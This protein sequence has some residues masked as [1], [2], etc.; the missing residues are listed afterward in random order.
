MWELLDEYKASNSANSQ[1]SDY[2][3][4]CINDRD[5]VEPPNFLVVKGYVQFRVLKWSAGNDDG[6]YCHDWREKGVFNTANE[7][8]RYISSVK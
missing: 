2:V 1:F 3:Q 6:I 8:A 5:L 4:R 7:A